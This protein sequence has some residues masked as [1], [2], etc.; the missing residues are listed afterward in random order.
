MAPRR[1]TPLVVSNNFKLVFL[2]AVGLTLLPILI[3]VI[4]SL[5]VTDPTEIQSRVISV[6][7]DLAKIGFGTVFGLIGGARMK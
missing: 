6:C 1:R 7:L 5:L 3:A 4:Y 2:S